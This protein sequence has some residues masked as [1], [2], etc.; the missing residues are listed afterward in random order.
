MK[1]QL[2]II[3]S[4]LTLS[5]YS[6]T[7]K[8]VNDTT[9]VADR[10][11][12][13]EYSK[14]DLISKS[15]RLLIQD[16]NDGNRPA[17]AQTLRYL[18]EQ[19]DDE[20]HTSLRNDERYLLMYWVGDY[21]NILLHITLA[22]EDTLRRPRPLVYP[23]DYT[24][25]VL[26]TQG[27]RDS[28]YD[29]I[30]AD[31][32]SM[33]FSSDTND[34]LHLFLDYLLQTASVDERNR[35][36][37]AFAEQYPDSPLLPATR[38]FISYKWIPGA[39]QFDVAFGGG[40]HFAS[41][42][43]TDWMSQS[44]GI[45][46]DLHFYYKR[47][48]L[49]MSVIA[50]F[51]TVKKDIALPDNTVWQ[52]GQRVEVDKVAIHAGFRAFDYKCWEVTPFA[53]LSFNQASHPY[54]AQRDSPEIKKLKLETS[55]SPVVGADI[56]IK[57]YQADSYASAFFSHPAMQLSAGIKA[58]FYPRLITT[59]GHDMLGQTVYL[60]LYLRMSLVSL[61]RMY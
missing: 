34:F 12:A 56:N 8:D 24:L 37:D 25:A 7:N 6:Q 49:G 1:K 2:T 36:T 47:F 48:R 31:Y 32:E 45:S 46:M 17:V 61:K 33:H 53:G 5:V 57:F 44:A 22:A 23:S 14:S 54:D 50:S 59:Q 40:A 21:T 3:F 16:F 15:R 30:V 55:L 10:I 26:L 35:R 41:G 28:Y 13:T 4:L 27:I 39:Y 11:A 52:A 20:Y 9:A 42:P 43:I 19:I 38:K 60:G 18:A 51:G 29:A 58:A